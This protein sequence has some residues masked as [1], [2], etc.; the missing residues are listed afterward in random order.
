VVNAGTAGD[1]ALSYYVMDAKFIGQP[2]SS[3]EALIF[4]TGITLNTVNTAVSAS[5]EITKVA[6]YSG[7]T[8]GS[9]T[10]ISVAYT[11]SATA[12]QGVDS[13]ILV[14]QHNTLHPEL[15]GCTISGATVV[16]YAGTDFNYFL[17]SAS[18]TATSTTMTCTV[19][20]NQKG[21]ASSSSFEVYYITNSSGNLFDEKLTMSFDWSVALPS[22]PF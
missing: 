5:L 11:I 3:T 12:A 18:S 22:A 1:Q 21:T 19:K 10:G 4:E 20:A 15:S 13:K 16:S 2:L 7:I 9:G 14:Y 8:V 17:F 6:L